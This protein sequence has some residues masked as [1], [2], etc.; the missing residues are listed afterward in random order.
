MCL[1]G[2][3]ISQTDSHCRCQHSSS[4]LRG[5][6]GG[7]W[8][9]M[10][11]RAMCWAMGSAG[12]WA[13][14]CGQSSE[15]M[16]HSRVPTAGNISNVLPVGLLNFILVALCSENCYCGYISHPAPWSVLWHHM[17]SQ[18]QFKKFLRLKET[19]LRSSGV[20]INCLFQVL[21]NFRPDKLYPGSYNKPEQGLGV[22]AM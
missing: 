6:A 9:R 22:G 18:P 13:V 3:N 4:A 8:H 11:W 14:L 1:E 5:S 16:W 15:V 21:W 19:N 2:Q 17:G 20:K 10:K 7:G 12:Q